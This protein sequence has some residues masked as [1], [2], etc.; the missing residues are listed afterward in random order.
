MGEECQYFK[1]DKIDIFWR[2][3]VEY[4]SE[5]CDVSELLISQYLREYLVEKPL[6]L[7]KLTVK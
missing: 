4:L 2:V 5:V 6:Y 3:L 1:S 7:S